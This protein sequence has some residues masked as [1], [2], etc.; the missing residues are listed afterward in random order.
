[1]RFTLGL[2]FLGSGLSFGA[3][4]CCVLPMVFML[5]GAGG[6]WLGLFAPL[7]GVAVPLLLASTALLVLS[8]GLAWRRGTIA[9]LRWRLAGTT[10]L[11]GLAWGIF[12]FQDGINDALIGMM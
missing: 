11:S 1:M 4:S 9:R 10:A 2:S 6:S 8:W 7:A 3:T 5:A 12:A